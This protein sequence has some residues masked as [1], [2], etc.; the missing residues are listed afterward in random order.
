[1]GLVKR[2]LKFFLESNDDSLNQIVIKLSSHK[3]SLAY[4]RVA[5]SVKHP[6]QRWHL[7]EHTIATQDTLWGLFHHPLMRPLHVAQNI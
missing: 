5:A 4:S 6:L 2:L 7:Q 1:M 3:I